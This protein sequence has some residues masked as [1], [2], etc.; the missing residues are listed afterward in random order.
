M[1]LTWRSPYPSGR[2]ELD[3]KRPMVLLQPNSLSAPI[4]GTIGT[5]A[6]TDTAPRIMAFKVGFIYMSGEYYSAEEQ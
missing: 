6:T 4:A 3:G 1:P 5:A 2:A